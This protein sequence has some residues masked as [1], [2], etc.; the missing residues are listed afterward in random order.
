MVVLLLA[1]MSVPLCAQ[2][3]APVEVKLSEWK[4]EMPAT[5]PAGP[6]TFKVANTGQKTHTLKIQA[7]GFEQKLSND[8][9]PGE[10]GEMTVNLKPGTYDVTC[11]I[12]FGAH[13][14]HGMQV[15]LTVH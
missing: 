3:G 14:K 13:K 4:I 11:P 12:G 8:L 2:T 1:S 5:L 7:K 9:K 15:T 6:T 10:N